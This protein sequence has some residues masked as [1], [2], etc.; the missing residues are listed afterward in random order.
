[1]PANSVREG[2]VRTAPRGRRLILPSKALGFARK[3][4][5]IILCRSDSDRKPTRHAMPRSVAFAPTLIWVVLRIACSVLVEPAWRATIG[6]AVS[7]AGIVA[8][9][10]A[11]LS[12]AA[13]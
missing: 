2:M 4:A 1:M 13:A 11:G 12:G 8:A 10:A 9:D 3:M 5:I 6:I 7:T